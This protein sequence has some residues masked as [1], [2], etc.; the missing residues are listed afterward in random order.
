MRRK[1]MALILIMMMVFTGILP[2]VSVKAQPVE[3]IITTANVSDIQKYG[4]V[5]L[6]L[7]RDELLDAGFEYGD[8]LEVSFLKQTMNLPL[9][10]D[11][12]D[13]NAGESGVF[14]RSTEEN[15]LLAINLRD[16]A[17][18]YGIAEKVIAEDESVSWKPARGVKG[19]FEVSISMLEKG[20]YYDEYLIHRL[21][22]S[23]DR[24]DFTDLTDAQFANFR[25]VTTKGIARGRLYRSAS[26]INPEYNRN[27]QADAA[28]KKAGVTTI[29]NLADDADTA[30]SYT[31]FYSTYYSQ[32]KFI[33]LNMSLDVFADDFKEKTAKGFRYLIAN[34]GVFLIHCTE[35]KNRTGFVVAVLESLM[36]AGIDEVVADYMVTYYNYYGITLED[37]RY[38]MIAENNIMAE[39]KKSFGIEDFE[40]VKLQDEAAEYLLEIGLSEEEIE[41]L[42]YVLSAA[43]ATLPVV[44]PVPEEVQE[45]AETEGANDKVAATE[46]VTATTEKQDAEKVEATATAENTNTA[47]EIAVSSETYIVQ[48]GDYL[49]AIAKK[50]LGAV[51]RWI[52]IYELNKDIIADPNMIF[53]G[54]ELKM[55]AH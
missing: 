17:T 40:G 34:P 35:G 27:N 38:E 44:Q 19:S 2:T 50:I 11:F 33:A 48:P 28:I 13:V 45:P 18:E 42:K 46:A 55:P 20:G 10:K 24:G 26:P 7:K 25:E 9:C 15:V 16:F 12:T 47:T 39:L 41:S 37:K 36:G 54:Q 30:K 4:N 43:D 49:I 21:S 32:Q 8:M 14:A 23:D 1:L 3:N 22:Y 29:M 52:E 51:E 6:E 31:G 5:V 53:I